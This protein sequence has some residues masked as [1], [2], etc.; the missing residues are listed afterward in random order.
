V[1]LCTTIILSFRVA[2]DDALLLP[3][4]RIDLRFELLCLSRYQH[5]YQ[6]LRFKGVRTTICVDPEGAGHEHGEKAQTCGMSSWDP[7]L[8]FVS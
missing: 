2:A 3:S 4:S 5:V 6:G 1:I 8:G 7:E